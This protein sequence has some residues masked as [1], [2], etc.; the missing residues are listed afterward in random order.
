MPHILTHKQRLHT[1]KAE[2]ALG[3][4]QNYISFDLAQFTIYR[5]SSGPREMVQLSALKAKPGCDD[6]FMDGIVSFEGTTFRLQCVRFSELSIEGYNDTDCHLI[7]KSIWIQTV[8][9]KPRDVYYRLTNPSHEY[10]RFHNVFL[11]TADLAKHFVDFLLAHAAVQLADFRSRFRDWLMG[12]HGKSTDIQEWIKCLPG[13]DF[14]ATIVAHVEYLWKE[15]LAVITPESELNSHLIWAEFLCK[16]VPLQKSTHSTDTKTVVTPF[17]YDCF[18]DLYFG[19]FLDVR[20]IEDAG[21]LTARLTKT[22]LGFASEPLT[23]INLPTMLPPEDIKAG[24][25]V[26]LPR[27]DKVSAWKADTN[28]GMYTIF[29]QIM[30]GC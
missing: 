14:R 19:S 30:I 12:V 21:T 10:R 17:V 1:L 23:S 9:G 28:F 4:E 29:N 26:R 27:D 8:Q 7:A 24:D 3:I 15:A 13:T 25:V 5:N 20:H 16:A 2:E 22:M 6:L 11:W 18:K